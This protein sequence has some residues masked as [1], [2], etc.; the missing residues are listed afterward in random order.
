MWAVHCQ[1]L[2][3]DVR[4]SRLIRSVHKQCRLTFVAIYLLMSCMLLL[5]TEV[6]QPMCALHEI[7]VQAISYTAFHWPT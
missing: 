7:C 5:D 1:L 6:A 4:M 2:L 3:N